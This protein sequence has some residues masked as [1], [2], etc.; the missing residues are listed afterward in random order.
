MPVQHLDGMDGIRLAA[1]LAGSENGPAVILL[2]G[3]G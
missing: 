3:G 1:D 2:H